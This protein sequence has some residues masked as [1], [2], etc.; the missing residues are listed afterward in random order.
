M[1]I[2]DFFILYKVL[3]LWIVAVVVIIGTFY[4]L[5]IRSECYN[6]GKKTSFLKEIPALCRGCRKNLVRN[7]GVMYNAARVWR[8]MISS[9]LKML[10]SITSRI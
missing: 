7:H 2:Y 10:G 3:L 1:G 5:A 9:K 8:K 4:Y 6:C